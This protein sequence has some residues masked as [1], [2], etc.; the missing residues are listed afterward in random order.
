M[1]VVVERTTGR[2]CFLGKKLALATEG[3][4][5]SSVPQKREAMA[6]QEPCFHYASPENMA[7][8]DILQPS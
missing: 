1:V 2:G 7:I 6:Q 8:P 5:I 4:K 3:G